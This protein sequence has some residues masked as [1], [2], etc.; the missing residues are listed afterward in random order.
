MSSLKLRADE[1]TVLELIRQGKKHREIIKLLGF[2]H[3]KVTSIV[4]R[5]RTWGALKPTK[6]DRI[7]AVGSDDYEIMTDREV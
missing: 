2:S 4:S 3:G 7:P 1:A 6:E 5:L